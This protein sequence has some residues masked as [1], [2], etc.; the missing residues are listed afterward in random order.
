MKGES[1]IWEFIQSYGIW[2][3]L[4]IA[5]LYLF[6]RGCGRGAGMV[7]I[8]A[9]RVIAVLHGGSLR[10]SVM[11]RWSPHLAI[12]SRIIETGPCSCAGRQ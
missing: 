4:D 1:L 3:V 5:A 9:V 11:K 7:V 6:A 8:A 10:T 12:G 2:T